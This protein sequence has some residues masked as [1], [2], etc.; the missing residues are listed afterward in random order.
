M[1]NNAVKSLGKMPSEGSEYAGLAAWAQ[2]N[3]V[4]NE[5]YY[6]RDFGGKTL[7]F[8]W[9]A[10]SGDAGFRRYFR[11]SV[12]IMAPEQHASL[13]TERK[14]Q[15]RRY[16]VTFSPPDKEKNHEFHRIAEFL[17]QRAVKVPMVLA[18]DFERGYFLQEDLGETLYLDHLA[19]PSAQQNIEGQIGD[20]A[21]EL[22]GQAISALLD[23]QVSAQSVSL[24]NLQAIFP[25]YDRELLQ[26]EMAL[27]PE[28]FIGHLMGYT[29][30]ESEREML[31][32]S[33]GFLC[34]S[35][36]AQPQVIVHRD[37]HSRN[38]VYGVGGEPGIIDFQDAVIGPITYDLVSLLRD[39][40]IAWPPE[41]VS[42][43]A[44]DYAVQAGERGLM[45]SVDDRVFLQWFDLMGLQR[46]IKVLGIFARLSLRDN[47]HAYLNDL[48][49]VIGYFRSVAANYE[50]LV[51]LLKWFD[52]ILMPKITQQ[53]WYQ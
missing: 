43:W 41:R 18:V 33:F 3:I 37:Y 30:S 22:Y 52:E 7:S 15:P 45:S 38:I 50:P 32:R 42:A 36:C 12:A 28:W 19:E 31:D 1:S 14:D 40:Y 17:S 48:P 11:L 49:L 34:D 47:K 21:D 27:F 35:A 26:G 10:I 9:C 6:Q 44:L 5:G 20:R 24:D 8:D 16:I 2:A 25:A 39:C 29:L 13:A 51:E 53:E 23:I 4:E 46:H